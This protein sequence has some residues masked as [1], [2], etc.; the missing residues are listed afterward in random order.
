MSLA[1]LTHSFF[2]RNELEVGTVILFCLMRL[3]STV[4]HSGLAIFF[5]W[6]KPQKKHKRTS[7]NMG[8]F[9]TPQQQTL[10]T[11]ASHALSCPQIYTTHA[12]GAPWAETPPIYKYTLVTQ[13]K[14][15]SFHSFCNM[16][17][18][19]SELWCH[20]QNRNLKPKT[21]KVSDDKQQKPTGQIKHHREQYREAFGTY[22]VR[23]LEYE[24]EQQDC[25]QKRATSLPGPTPAEW[26]SP[27]S[28]YPMLFYLSCKSRKKEY[29][30]LSLGHMLDLWG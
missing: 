24:A 23:D 26:A 5:S 29:D 11:S 20:W 13:R 9:E 3:I 7:R 15:S 28:T 2:Y 18:W 10:D 30:W 8:N 6:Q 25:T 14:L 16:G 4:W 22:E 1:E 27:K 21:A 12:V 19:S 17:H